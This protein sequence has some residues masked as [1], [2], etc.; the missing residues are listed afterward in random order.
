MA[1]KIRTGKG[2]KVLQFAQDGEFYYRSG[3]SKLEKNDLVGAIASYR[4]ALKLDPQN[5]DAVLG[6]AEIL[7]A[8]GR[9]EESN[10]LLMVKLREEERPAEAYFGMGCNFFAQREYDQARM[11]FDKY[12]DEEPDGEFAYTAYDMAEAIDDGTARAYQ[13]GPAA[14]PGY[15]EAEQA[16]RLMDKEDFKGAIELLEKTVERYPEL[17]YA[18]NSLALCYYCVHD[19]SKATDQVG[20]VLKD[21]PRNIQA[22]CNLAIFMRG[23]RDDI[24]LKRQVDYLKTVETEDP[25][26]LNRMCITFMDLREFAAALPIAKK[27]CSKK[28]YD[29]ALTHRLALCAYYTGDWAYALSCYDKLL[30]IDGEDSIA[31]FYK[32]VCRAAIMGAPKAM[33]LMLNYQVPAEEVIARIKK[34]NEYIH[35]PRERLM[36]MWKEGGDVRTAAKWG[37]TLP[38]SSVKRAILS[39]IASF[40]DEAAEEILRDF[41]LRKEE[42]TELK[43]DTFAMLKAIDAKEPYLS[44]IDGELVESRVSLVPMMP[45]GM[46]KAYGEV[47]ESC[48][49]YM[50]GIRDDACISAAVSIWSKYVSGL[51]GYQPISKGQIMAL[52]AALE[53]EACRKCGE[54]VTKLELCSKYGISMIRFNNAMG[55]LS[56]GEGKE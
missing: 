22:H 30:R 21:D 13:D 39:F 27:L 50:R 12:L 54:K 20:A 37:L 49:S 43:R 2:G 19:Y 55:K 4:M 32:G 18:R 44:Y 11:S 38:D 47:M 42:S 14:S 53:Y 25:D 10:R 1:E 24:G 23:A 51:S 6:I 26:D 34:L 17:A 8:M 41:A 45:K 31:R 5:Y 16:R 52:A 3:S 56:K 48:V 15:A 29:P 36:E 9:T 7:T 35:I 46:P 28:S 40:R 33:S